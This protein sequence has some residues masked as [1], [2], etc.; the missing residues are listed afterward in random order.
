[1]QVHM[2]VKKYIKDYRTEYIVKPNGKP[3]AKAVYIGKYYAYKADGIVLARSKVLFLVCALLAVLCT[4]APLCYNN[5]GS[6]VIYVALPNALALFPLFYLGTGVF[7][8]F[9]CKPP[10]ISEF[11]DKGPERVRRS[12][13]GC[14][15]L[16]A[17]A[18]LTRLFCLIKSGFSVGDTVALV[19]LLAATA[20][21]VTMFLRR[22]DL[23]VAEYDGLEDEEDEE[24]EE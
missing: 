9:Y 23:A 5:A 11:K 19:L 15:V 13:A 4:L 17:A 22:A 1:M 18:A 24:G 21:A 16:C 20:S 2:G 7:N 12:S 10:L 8:L 6:H 3:G 14:A